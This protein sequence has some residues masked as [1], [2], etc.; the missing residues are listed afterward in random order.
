MFEDKFTPDGNLLSPTKWSFQIKFLRRLRIYNLFFIISHYSGV[1]ASQTWQKSWNFNMFFF[2]LR[3]NGRAWVKTVFIFE[4]RAL[5][6]P[7]WLSF[8]SFGEH[9]RK[10]PILN[11]CEIGWNEGKRERNPPQVWGSQ[12][13]TSPKKS[14]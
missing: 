12:N 4:L 13:L 1:I 7:I 6:Y 3:A 5:G 2:N 11:R 14:K 9:F 10:F 8:V